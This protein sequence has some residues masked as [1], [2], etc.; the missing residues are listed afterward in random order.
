MPSELAKWR[1]A[2]AIILRG[3]HLALVQ[4]SLTGVRIRTSLPTHVRVKGQKAPCMSALEANKPS[5][6]CRQSGSTQNDPSLQVSHPIMGLAFA[7]TRTMREALSSSSI[8]VCFEKRL[9]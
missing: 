1:C 6:H 2:G 9:T 7:C 4:K 3:I 5:L 8:S